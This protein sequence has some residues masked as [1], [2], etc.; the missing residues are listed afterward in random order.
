MQQ[1]RLASVYRI[2]GVDDEHWEVSQGS[3]AEPIATFADRHS[4]LAYAMSLANEGSDS[5]LP[6]WRRDR[7]W[8]NILAA[9]PFRSR[10]G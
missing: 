3:C 9:T 4:A 7:A 5:P 6:P 2:C 10:N 1:N 8:R